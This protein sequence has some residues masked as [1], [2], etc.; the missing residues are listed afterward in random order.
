MR[1]PA[2]RGRE[3]DPGSHAELREPVVPM[4]KEKPKRRQP[5]G[6]ST[7]AEHWDGPTCRSDEGWQ[8]GR[9]KG[10][11]SSRRRSRSTGDRRKCVTTAK[12]FTIPKRLVYEAFE[13]VKA[14][15]GRFDP[16]ERRAQRLRLADRS[17]VVLRRPC[18]MRLGLATNL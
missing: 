3:P 9:S 16:L 11:G 5:R 1:R 18:A 8:C 4:P 7:E 15:A 10:V 6:E 13:A 17:K 12:P 14:N 2:Y